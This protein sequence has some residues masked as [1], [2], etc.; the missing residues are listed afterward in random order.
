MGINTECDLAVEVRPGCADEAQLRERVVKLR[1]NFLGGH[2]GVPP[3]AVEG[4]VPHAGGSLIGATE[5]LRSEGRPL[6]SFELPELST[7]EEEVLAESELLDPE[8][9][10]WRWRRWSPSRWRPWARDGSNKGGLGLM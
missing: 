9:P 2:L 1:W 3:G 4:A 6:V 10:T 7:V 5:M 8:R